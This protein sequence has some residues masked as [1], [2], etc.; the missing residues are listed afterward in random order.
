M[1]AYQPREYWT[2]VA[3]EIGQRPGLSVIAGLDTPFYEYKRAKF[4]ERFLRAIPAA[5]KTILEVGCGPGGNLIEL[6]TAGPR[7]L[8][9]CDIS[10]AMLDLAI[11][12]TDDVGGVEYVET[13][14][15]T[16][17]FADREFE[18]TFTSTVLQH[19]L[20]DGDLNG[21]LGEMCRVTD[22]AIY[23]FE[24]TSS[25]RKERYSAV[26]RPVEDYAR[27]C[28]RNGFEIVEAERLGVYASERVAGFLRRVLNRPSPKAGEP[29]S[30]LNR[31][32]ER[33]AL[34]LTRLLDAVVPQRRGLTKM[35]FRRIAR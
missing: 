13:D 16:L 18:I 25:K 24:D 22:E 27:V 23:L 12:N 6:A 17:P 8:V 31:A 5:G 29:V 3:E 9:G 1:K 21:L 26:L 15:K 7:K 30:P 32:F 20:D 11:R 33:A 10:R 2:R 19:N 14:G 34:P 4:L 35:A 28:T